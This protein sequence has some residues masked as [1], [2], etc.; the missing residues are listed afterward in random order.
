MTSLITFM[1]YHCGL[2]YKALIREGKNISFSCM[3]KIHSKKQMLDSN[4][5]FICIH[6]KEISNIKFEKVY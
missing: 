1:C 6:C 5:M 2:I 3:D 4:G